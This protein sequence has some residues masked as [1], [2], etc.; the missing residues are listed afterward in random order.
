MKVLL[1]HNRYQFAGG[2]DGVVKAEKLLLEANEHHVSLLEVSNQDITN[3]WDKVAT[4]VSAIYSYSAKEQVSREI[5]H[6]R[7]DIV[8]VHNFFPLLSPSI[9]DA[10]HKHG[11]PVVQ[12]LHNYRLACPKAMPFRNGK[13]CED[14]IGELIPWPSIVYGCYRN[15]RV[16]SSVVTAM[17]TWHRLRNTWQERV[18]AYIV[19]TEFQK[20]K[21]VQ[22]GLPREKIYVK[23]NFIFSPDAT[24]KVYQRDQYLLF[25]GRLSEE[26]GISILIDTYIQENLHIPLKIVG[27]GPL[28]QKLQTKV[29]NSGYY[30]VIE[31]LGFQDKQVVLSLMQHA[32]LLVF[33]SI[34]YEGF[35]LTIA[36]A[37]ACGLPVLVSKL[38]GLTEI[39]EDGVN[40]LY[41]EAGNSHDLA[42]QIKWASTHDEA[43][44]SMSKGA[45]DSYKNKYSSE[46]NY[47]QLINIYQQLILK[48]AASNT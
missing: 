11:V 3:A 25:V 4:A 10:C 5:I 26:K 28:R 16:Q 36:E 7:P 38:G 43:M 1:L 15:S 47:Q 39:V 48:K 8:H 34:W 30:H 9:Y 23:P 29:Q 27:D 41:F 21:M 22:A 6:F 42:Q 19:F 35:P 20:E 31:F 13:V 14:C 40:G 24:A 37:F 33:P 44:L 17:I 18:D 12:T 45:L 2:E 46:D 32:N